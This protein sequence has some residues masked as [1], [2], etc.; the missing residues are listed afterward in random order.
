[1]KITQIT[2]NPAGNIL[3]LGDDGNLYCGYF[4]AG[5]DNLAKPTFQWR[6]MP[7]IPEDI[8]EYKF[9]E[10]PTASALSLARKKM[11]KGQPKL[12]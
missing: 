5:I 10:E 8:Y 4:V 12:V 2:V 3:A 9:A 7:P 11:K 1:M 6:R